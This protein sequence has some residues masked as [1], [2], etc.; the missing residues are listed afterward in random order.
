MLDASGDPLEDIR[1]SQGGFGFIVGDDRAIDGIEG[2]GD[3]AMVSVGEEW[4][5][6]SACISVVHHWLDSHAG[7]P[8]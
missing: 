1:E 2:L 7:K 5:L 3:V 4:L 8:S 6:G